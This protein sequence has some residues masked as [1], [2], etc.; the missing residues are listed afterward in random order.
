MEAVT[1]ADDVVI[2]GAENEVVV[3]AVVGITISTVPALPSVP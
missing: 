2:P 1:T 3:E